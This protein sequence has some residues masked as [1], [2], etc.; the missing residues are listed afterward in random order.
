MKH[1]LPLVICLLAAVASPATVIDLATG[2]PT[3]AAPQ[4]PQVQMNKVSDGYDVTYIFPY[5]QV[6]AGLPNEGDVW[7]IQGLSNTIKLGLPLLP[8]KNDSFVVPS[9]TDATVTLGKVEYIDFTGKIKTTTE[10]L[11]DNG[12]SLTSTEPVSTSGFY[13]ENIVVQDPIQIYRD[14]QILSVSIN[15]VQYDAELSKIRVY[16]KLTYSVRFN[17]A[18]SPLSA[19]DMIIHHVDDDDPYLSTFMLNWQQQSPAQRA[20]IGDISYSFEKLLEGYLIITT[21]E[22]REAVNKFANWKKQLGFK[23]IIRES[24]YWNSNSI[25]AAVNSV[26]N[27]GENLRYLLIVGD[28]RDVPGKFCDGAYTDFFYACMDGENDF[29]PDLYYGRISVKSN[30]EA[31]TVF[32]KI[33]TY[34]QNPPTDQSFYTTATHCS[35]FLGDST[36]IREDENRYA[37]TV[38]ELL[39]K[40]VS[41]GFTVNRH[42]HKY[43]LLYPEQWYEDRI[44]GPMTVNDKVV[45][46]KLGCD[47]PQSLR[48]P[49]YS[50]THNNLDIAQSIN[51]GSLYV[52]YRGHGS[53]YNWDLPKFTCDDI[54]S[55][56]NTNKLPVVFSI[57]CMTGE[58][59]GPYDCFAETFLKKPDGG[60]VGIIAAAASTVTSIN[61]TFAFGLFKCIWDD[62]F[63]SKLEIPMMQSQKHTLRL[64]AMM[65]QGCAQL[66]HV[67]GVNDSEARWNNILYHCFGDPSMM[68][69]SANPQTIFTPLVTKKNVGDSIR[70]S[71]DIPSGCEACVYNSTQDVS[72]VFAIRGSVTVPSSDIISIC[73]FG[74]NKRCKIWNSAN[75]LKSSA[76]NVESNRIVREDR[77]WVKDLKDGST[78][79][80]WFEGTTEIDGRIYHNLHLRATSNPS[81]PRDPR[82]IYDLEDV[83]AYM[84]EE[85]GRVYSRTAKGA[86][87]FKPYFTS[88]LI[89][90]YDKDALAYDFNLQSGDVMKRFDNPADW[91]DNRVDKYGMNDL[92]VLSLNTFESCGYAYNGYVV[93]VVGSGP[94]VWK[95]SRQICEIAGDPFM[96][97]CFPAMYNLF[98]CNCGDIRQTRVYDLENNLL[99]DSSSYSMLSATDASAG[100]IV[101]E[102]GRVAVQDA[103][104]ACVVTICDVAGHV[105]QT[106]TGRYC[107]DIDLRGLSRGIYIVNVVDGERTFT[108]KVAI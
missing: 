18:V 65:A 47:I 70:Y 49:N 26:W 54:L 98:D 29:I 74:E 97:L 99:F 44:K 8:Y 53:S 40:A 34:E 50:W 16:K 108:G 100:Q 43:D 103:S 33:R 71:F 41:E 57:A 1:L 30:S 22:F 27:Q 11:Y 89:N 104:D 39:D 62:T 81:N 59:N 48:Y 107:E 85:D 55:L 96:P 75:I 51:Q 23:V 69:Y 3:E 36:M 28:Q 88:R 93:S 45:Y 86:E 31:N 63:N 102:S 46:L 25:W 42:Y 73:F 105:L 17:A 19:D 2:R 72:R 58:F 14:R 10:I 101:I 37:M 7:E 20:S 76:H 77:V 4:L 9:G 95:Y 12:Q 5:V 83:V 84:R 56:S 90:V 67:F 32:D 38:E 24:N 82:E 66:R 94:Y 91:P 52:L 106:I 35:A 6:T 80:E 87:A 64:G 21:P 15:P 61:N 13:P 68:M 78:W 92:N 60:C 79:R